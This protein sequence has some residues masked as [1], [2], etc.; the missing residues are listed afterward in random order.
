[1]MNDDLPQSVEALSRQIAALGAALAEFQ[2]QSRPALE[3][4]ITGEGAGMGQLQET[5]A[6]VQAK[7][8]AMQSAAVRIAAVGTLDARQIQETMMKIH[9]QWK[10]IGGALDNLN[11]ITA[12]AVTKR[13]LDETGRSIDGWAR[14]WKTEALEVERAY[15]S[16]AQRARVD[17]VYRRFASNEPSST[18]MTESDLSI[19]ELYY[20][21]AFSQADVGRTLGLSQPAI[22]NR[23]RKIDR[24]LA[25]ELVLRKLQAVA[26]IEGW[27]AG[28]DGSIDMEAF[29]FQFDLLARRDDG[30][31][32]GIEVKVGELPSMTRL[33]EWSAY[34]ASFDPPTYPASAIF[35]PTELSA[36]LYVEQDIAGALKKL[37]TSS[38]HQLVEFSDIKALMPRDLSLN[39]AL[40]RAQG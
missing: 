30:T 5:A 10:E 37:S 22:A 7:L 38:K 1:M 3:A 14:R 23:L 17:N 16:L 19:A 26:E 27:D 24:A 32:I 18:K 34:L 13:R 21:G 20:Y 9:A 6:A 15:R 28:R 35:D 25:E 4:A 39:A 31:E 2:R 36:G 8:D 11:M 33:A 12:M 40:K 29:D